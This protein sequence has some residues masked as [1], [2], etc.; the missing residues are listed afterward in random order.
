MNNQIAKSFKN[1]F[2]S[3]YINVNF[4][5]MQSLQNKSNSFKKMLHKMNSIF[6]KP[7]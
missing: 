5:N 6:L 1:D 2:A 7:H 4:D 3:D